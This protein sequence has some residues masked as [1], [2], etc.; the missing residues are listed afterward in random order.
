M[1]A[2][3]ALAVLTPGADT[4]VRGFV[5]ALDARR[6]EAARR[7]LSAEARA[8]LDEPALRAVAEAIAQRY[9]GLRFEH[10]GFTGDGAVYRATLATGDGGSVAMR[11]WLAREPRSA[12]WRLTAF[13]LPA[14]D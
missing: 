9:G 11:A 13:E 8:L 14:R 5:D 12:L 10:G 6:L 1:R 2:G 3:V 7:Q 4:V